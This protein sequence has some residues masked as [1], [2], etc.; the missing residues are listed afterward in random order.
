M[1]AN[2]EGAEEGHELHEFSRIGLKPGREERLTRR[3]QRPQRT[4]DRIMGL[5]K[6]GA[7]EKE[8]AEPFCFYLAEP[9]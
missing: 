9:L 1:D 7:T 6:K 3:A 5:Q 2:K 8:G 4:E